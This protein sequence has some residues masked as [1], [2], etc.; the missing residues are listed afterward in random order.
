MTSDFTIRS[1]FILI[2][3]L[4]LLP[5]CKK[6]IEFNHKEHIERA[7]C[8]ECHV[9]ALVGDQAG[10]P[11]EETC[12]TCHSEKQKEQFLKF[13]EMYHPFEREPFLI[14]TGELMFSHGVHADASI[15]CET[16]HVNI[17]NVKHGMQAEIPDM[18]LCI[19]CHKE[20]GRKD[21]CSVCHE[22]IRKGIP[23]EDHKKNW[24]RSHG[25]AMSKGSI[26][27][28]KNNCSI[29]HSDTSCVECHRE[30]KPQDHNHFWKEKGHGTMALMDRKRCSMC[31][32][33]DYCI[34][35]HQQVAPRTHSAG[36][37]VAPIYN[38]C[39]TCHFPYTVTRCQS[40][41]PVPLHPIALP[42]PLFPPEDH[43]V[44]HDDCRTCHP[45]LRAMRH[46]DP[47]IDCKT[48]HK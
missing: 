6:K 20:M 5:S 21:E 39:L 22:K 42:R 38:H 29:C 7:E 25:M 10:M 37:K 31:H 17:D 13:K 48:C 16:C 36:W 19:D 33:T 43:T 34:Q 1:I 11:T 30:T 47:G 35:C 24:M 44:G 28:N 32:R 18:D 12:L 3:A 41:H 40:C 9:E 45:S 14:G 46:Q 2:A 23:P 26:R 8:Q 27:G 4:F 15:D